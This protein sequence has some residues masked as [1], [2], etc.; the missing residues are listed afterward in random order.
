[1]FHIPPLNPPMQSMRPCSCAAIGRSYV[2]RKITLIEMAAMANYVP[3]SPAVKYDI[4]T[5]MLFACDEA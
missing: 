5:P 4:Y 1:M 2:L 3:L